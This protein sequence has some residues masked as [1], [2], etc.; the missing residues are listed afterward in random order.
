[1]QWFTI[2]HV[3]WA[4]SVLS[5]AGLFI[6]I[7][8]LVDKIRHKST[9]CARDGSGCERVT[10]SSYS[11]FLRVPLALWGSVFY[12]LVLVA[13]VFNVIVFTYYVTPQGVD[14]SANLMTINTW[15]TS[16]VFT[17]VPVSTI[18]AIRL[19]YLQKKI[20]AWCRW[21]VSQEIVAILLTLVSLKLSVSMVSILKMLLFLK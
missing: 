20:G 4:S 3:L 7:K 5:F 19:L 14:I 12:L 16:I 21:C 11:T 17:L 1:M 8:L 15:F 6:S 10:N 18:I 9:M 2:Q 13:S